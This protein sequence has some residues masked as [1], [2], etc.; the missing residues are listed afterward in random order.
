M[1][2]KRREQE[3]SDEGIESVHRMEASQIG[4]GARETPGKAGREPW[5][6]EMPSLAT[7]SL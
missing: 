7:C 1:K 5:R 3:T 2:R 4:G 6:L